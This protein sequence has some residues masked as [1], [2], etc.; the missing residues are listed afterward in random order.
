MKHS[1][2]TMALGVAFVAGAFALASPADAATGKAF[3][4]GKTIK[5][6]IATGPGGGHDFYA[7]LF[8]R[9]MQKALPGST[10]VSLNRP[11]A[12]HRI[13]AN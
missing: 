4:D 1:V 13:G 6:I 2:K 10:F 7:R 8:A 5:W 3:Y 12:G 9:H 11:G